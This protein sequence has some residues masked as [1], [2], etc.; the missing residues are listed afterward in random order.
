MSSALPLLRV[1]IPMVAAHTTG[2]AI[3]KSFHPK[4]II[5]IMKSAISAQHLPNLMYSVIVAYSL[6]QVADTVKAAAKATIRD[7]VCITLM[8]NQ[9]S[10]KKS[11]LQMRDSTTTIIVITTTT[12]ISTACTLNV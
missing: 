7:L 3:V 9:R 5:K 1:I 8:R 10:S 4:A 2:Q 12:T 6:S 11:H